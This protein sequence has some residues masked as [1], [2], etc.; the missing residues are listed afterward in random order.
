MSRIGKLRISC[1]QSGFSLIEVLLSVVILSTGL[2]LIN[3][4]LLRSL[5]AADYANTRARADQ[6]V[7]K[8]IWEV[9]SLAWAERSRP[10]AREEGVLL[11]GKETFPYELQSV[12]VRGSDFLYEVR[13]AVKWLN[14]GREK[15]LTRAFYARL[16]NEPK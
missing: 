6:A 4:T 14:S 12:G 8:K 3:Q 7:E 11:E 9:K 10:P 16:P 1:W 5:T 13:L 15:G 2:V